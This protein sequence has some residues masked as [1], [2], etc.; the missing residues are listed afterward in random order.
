LVVKSKVESPPPVVFHDIEQV[1]CFKLL[2]VHF[3]TDPTNWDLQFD[4]LL[5]KAGKHMYI[6][7]I[8]KSYGYSLDHLPYLVSIP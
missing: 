6:L 1:E 8:C 2:G 5:S 4:N 7:R 3:H